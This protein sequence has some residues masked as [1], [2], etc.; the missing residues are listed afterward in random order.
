MQQSL[1]KMCLGFI[2]ALVP[3]LSAHAEADFPNGNIRFVAPNSASTPPDI[4][5]RIIAKQ[6]T[7]DEALARDRGEPARW[8]HHNCRE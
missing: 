1:R 3:G 7:E 8:H 4:I 5:S 6:L 2:I